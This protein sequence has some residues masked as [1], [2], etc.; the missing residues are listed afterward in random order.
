MTKRD[1]TFVQV[2]IDPEKKSK[3]AEKLEKEGK[4]ITDI[5]NEWIDDYI[6]GA[7]KVDVVELKGDVVEL[8]QRLAVLEQ[9]LATKEGELQGESAA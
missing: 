6:N 8:R 1:R 4:K 5:V 3:F 9:S 7:E 2:Q